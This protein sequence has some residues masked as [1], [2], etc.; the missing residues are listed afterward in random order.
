[1]GSEMA[2]RLYQMA[3]VVAVTCAGLLFG[4][5]WISLS[6]HYKLLNFQ[7]VFVLIPL[8][9]AASLCGTI[10]SVAA[11]RIRRRG[12]L[13][14]LLVSGALLAVSVLAAAFIVYFLSGLSSDPL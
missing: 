7:S 11:L 13:V 14:S 8:L 2:A 10:S 3:S 9:F 1:M 4:G 6:T 5:L 12:A